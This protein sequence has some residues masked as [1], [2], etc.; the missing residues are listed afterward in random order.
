MDEPIIITG[1][2]MTYQ[3]FSQMGFTQVEIADTD[4][5]ISGQFQASGV[6]PVTLRLST[7]QARA[8]P[9]ESLVEITVRVLRK[10]P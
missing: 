10:G 6:H 3:R 9:A 4:R 5:S 1:E 2:V 8:I 7:E